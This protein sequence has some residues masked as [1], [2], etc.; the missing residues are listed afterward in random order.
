[1][2]VPEIPIDNTGKWDFQH[3]FF[4]FHFPNTIESF[5]F[6]NKYMKIVYV[7]CRLQM[8]AMYG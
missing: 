8:K 5:N 1:M 6:T 2:S 3:E 4:V 7:D